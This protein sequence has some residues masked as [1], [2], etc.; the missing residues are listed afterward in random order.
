VWHSA[1]YLIWT[2][3]VELIEFAGTLKKQPRM[4]GSPLRY[5]EALDEKKMVAP[6]SLR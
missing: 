2:L 6:S 5:F 1:S 3:G 4:D